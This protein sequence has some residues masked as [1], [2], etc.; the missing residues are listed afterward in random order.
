MALCSDKRAAFQFWPGDSVKNIRSRF[1]NLPADSRVTFVF[2]R[3]LLIKVILTCTLEVFFFNDQHFIRW[4]ERMPVFW[5]WLGLHHCKFENAFGVVLTVVVCGVHCLDFL[6][7]R[8]FDGTSATLA[9]CCCLPWNKADSAGGVFLNQ[10]LLLFGKPCNKRDV[11][12][13]LSLTYSFHV[14]LALYV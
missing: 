4:R 10:F 6:H 1:L 12:S 9:C 8:V 3:L 2:L 14:L 13:E 5:S 11:Q 7:C